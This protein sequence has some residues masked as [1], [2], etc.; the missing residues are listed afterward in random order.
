MSEDYVYVSS[1]LTG[2][3]PRRRT[4]IDRVATVTREALEEGLLDTYFPGDHS[5]P[6]S[7][8]TP[9]EVFWLDFERVRKS[10]G[11]VALVDTPAFGVGMEL[12]WAHQWQKPIV[13]AAV[14]DEVV[15]SSVVSRIVL[16]IP[17]VHV[18]RYSS[19]AD[20]R[21]GMRLLVAEG[22]FE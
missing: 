17:G 19:L 1:A 20:L 13:V 3:D 22:V 16:G 9:S 4:W 5:A 12:A 21:E 18:I 15:G 14:G 2:L 6:G 10:R 11:L 7:P 8:H